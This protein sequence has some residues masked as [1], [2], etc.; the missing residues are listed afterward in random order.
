VMADPIN[1]KSMEHRFITQFLKHVVELMLV[2]CPSTLYASHLGPLMC[3]IFEHMQYRLDKSWLPVV[4]ATSMAEATK[5]LT[6]QDCEKAAL[7]ASRGNEEWF[8]YYY[9]H[10]GLFVGD[11]DS[12]TAEAAVE[13]HRV[14]IGRTFS[15]VLQA[16]LALK[17]DWALVLAN[18]SKEE[19]AA[20]RND[21]SNFKGPANSVHEEGCQLNADGTRKTENQAAVDARKMLRINALC[22]FLLLENERIAGS[23][24]MTVIQ[25]MSYPDAYTCRRI[26]RICHRILETVAWS[27]TYSQLLGQ[28]MFTQAVK[29]IAT[30][31]KWMVGIE[32]DMIAVIRDSYCRL[33]LGQ[34]LQSGGQG[35]GL[36]QP[37]SL[38][39][40]NQYEQAKTVDRP[41]QGGGILVIPSDMPRQIL[42]SLPGIGIEFVE[43]FE[44]TMKRKR[45][46]KDQKD[47]IRD[48]LRVAADNLKEMNPT[49]AN[50]AASGLFDRAVEEESLLHYKTQQKAVPDL[51]EKLVTRS[52]MAKAS[53]KKNQYESEGLSAFQL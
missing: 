49:L 17:G 30:E 6:T 24:T 51:P 4:G 14:E 2:S 34:I 29:N 39:N 35:P 37:E 11:L 10:S 31:P 42:L 7:L 45:A 9:A 18:Q 46:S 53:K 21:S 1:L 23:L 40:P 48:M 28:Q 20:K 16:A 27:P 47:V 8:S 12:V 25:A 38:V 5:A 43:E 36:Q 52:Q 32:W 41:L 13:K 44:R 15:D 26:T 3:P 19:Q 50:A 33:V 22:H